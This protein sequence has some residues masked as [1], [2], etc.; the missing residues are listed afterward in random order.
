MTD[1][2]GRVDL[3]ENNIT[4][5]AQDLLS[6]PTIQTISDFRAVWNQQFDVFENKLE[7]TVRDLNVLQILY[8]NLYGYV[9]SGTFSGTAGNYIGESF[10][11]INK[12]LK[13]YPSRLYYD[14]DNLLTETRYSIG[15]SSYITKNFTYTS[16]LLT[17]I[18]LRG[19]PTPTTSLN[20]NFHYS[21]EILTGVTYN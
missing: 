5:L 3:V 12:N 16:G 17:R 2:S 13:Q 7:D 15:S 18:E 21:G 4:F 19:E 20:K 10:E 14:S 1:L 6:R 8:S 9:L 11:T